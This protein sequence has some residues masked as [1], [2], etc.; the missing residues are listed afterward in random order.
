VNRLVSCVLAGLFLLTCLRCP[1]AI[2]QGP[3]PAPVANNLSESIISSARLTPPLRSRLIELRFSPDGKSLLFQDQSAI[4]VVSLHP[5]RIQLSIPVSYVLPARFSADSRSVVIATSDMTVS[6]WNLAEGKLV[7]NRT[8]G[9]GD[10][11]LAATLSPHGRHYACLDRYSVLHVFDSASGKDVLKARMGERVPFNGLPFLVPYHRDLARS[12]PFG[13]FVTT[14]LPLSRESYSP[15][16]D[17]RFSAGGRFLVA[18]NRNDHAD[19]FD[20]RTK[21]MLHLSKTLRDALEHGSFA[22]AGSGRILSD[23]AAKKGTSELIS[24]PGG[25]K[26]K[27]IPFT[28][29]LRGTSSAQYVIA[30]PEGAKTANVVNVGSGAKVAMITTNPSDVL[31]GRILYCT[32]DGMISLAKIGENRLDLGLRTPAPPLPVLHA[33]AVSPSLQTLALGITGR[34]SVYRVQTGKRLGAFDELRGAWCES[35]EDCYLQVPGEKDQ[36]WK[37]DKF[38]PATAAQSGAWSFENRPIQNENISSGPVML[39]HYMKDM[40]FPFGKKR[41]PYELHALDAANGKRLWMKAFGGYVYRRDEQTEVPLVFTDP[42]GDRV[43]LG[44]PAKSHGARQAAEHFEPLKQR[45][46]QAKVSTRDSVFEVLDARTGKEVGAALV[47]LAAGPDS[48]DEAFSEGD[49]LILVRQGRDFASVSLSTQAVTQTN[50]SAYD[51]SLCGA[52]ALLSVAVPG[53]RLLLYDLKKNAVRD[54]FSFRSNVVYSH[55]SAGAK[56]LLVLTQE[57]MVYVLRV[58]RPSD[59]RPSDVNVTNPVRPAEPGASGLQRR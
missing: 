49:W 16:S 59:V 30:T 56:R 36:D 39:K 19:A 14:E 33:A 4:Y 6:I 26:E 42:Q 44:W 15:D 18:L 40:I 5:P 23:G 55:F 29:A 53:G 31:D 41:F 32:Y 35:D 9:S 12:Q 52:R 11:C 46:H 27:K 54:Q 3:A 37:I 50:D 48:F 28:G 47:Q 24:F 10:A 20:I 58:S 13:Y 21:K 1:D 25:R 45:F 7:Q 57:Q 43:V 2:A 8:L 17:L 38:D 34:G 51:V 22:F